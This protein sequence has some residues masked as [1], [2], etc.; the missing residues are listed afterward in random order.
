MESKRKHVLLVIDVQEKTASHKKSNEDLV[1]QCQAMLD[2]Q[3]IPYTVAVRKLPV[4]D[5]WFCESDE[6]IQ[7]PENNRLVSRSKPSDAIPK[8][9]GFKSNTVKSSTGGNVFTIFDL[10]ETNVSLSHL[11]D[12]TSDQSVKKQVSQE[13]DDNILPTPRIIVERKT[14]TDL[15]SSMSDGRY[16]D[17]KARLINSDAKDVVLLIEGYDG[18]QEKDDVQK[19]KLL[20]TFSH[21]MFRDRL[22]VYHTRTLTETFEFLHHTASEL[23]EGKCDRDAGFYERT[24]YTDNIKMT[25]KANLTPEKGLE[26][27]LATVP[28]VSTKMARA[29][30]ENYKSMHELMTAYDK[31]PNEKTK[32][33]M[34]ADF[35]FKGPSG[36]EQRLA[37]R[38]EKIY[39]YLHNIPQVTDKDGEDVAKPKKS[40]TKADGKPSKAKKLKTDANLG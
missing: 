39:C 18:Q 36:K 16:D 37:S 24:K 22:H 15:L 34:L 5:V 3:Q 40:R 13:T 23:S 28:G 35:K 6:E 26:M 8:H 20:S 4:G 7:I 9:D 11:L 25:K 14:V 17:Q 29:V 1:T 19:K 21:A 38:S 32:R 27:Q 2:K 31:C 12:C 30:C 10:P 33:N